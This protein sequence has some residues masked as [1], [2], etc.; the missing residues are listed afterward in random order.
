MGTVFKKTVTKAMPEGAELFSHKGERWARW[1]NAKGKLRKARVTT[2]E[3]GQDRI[4]FESGKYF[5]KYRDGSDVV[6][7][8]ATGCRD[9]DAARSFL[10]DLERRAELVKSGVITSGE[11]TVGIHGRRAISEHVKE[12]LEHQTAKGTTEGHRE[13]TRRFLERITHDCSFGLLTNLDCEKLERWMTHRQKENMSA[14]TRNAYR[15]AAVACGSWLVGSGRMLHNPFAKAP[16]ADQKS[17][18]RR[19]RRA[20]TEGELIKV[21]DV[22][23][24][25]PMQEARTVRRG[26]RKGEAYANLRD[27]TKASLERLGWERALIYKT[28]ILTGLRK[29]ELDSLTVGQTFLDE[30]LPY[31]ELNAADEKNRQGSSIMLRDD[32]AADLRGWLAAELVRLQ[33]EAIRNGD[34]IP[35]RLPADMP[36]FNVPSGLLRILDRDLKAAGIAKRDERGRTLDVHALRTTFGTLLSKGGVA[37]RTAQAAM[38]HSDI[39]LTMQ[40]YT[41]PKLLDVR[42]A[43]DSLPTLPLNDG[44]GNAAE[45]ARA[46]GTDDLGRFP[47]SPKFAPKLARWLANDFVITAAVRAASGESSGQLPGNFQAVSEH[48]AGNVSHNVGK[49]PRHGWRKGLQV[50]LQ[51]PLESTPQITKQTGWRPRSSPRGVRLGVRAASVESS[52]EFPGNFRAA[53]GQFHMKRVSARNFPEIFHILSTAT[54]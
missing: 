12:Y 53:S 4:V 33:A 23:R 54:I 6:R 30:S 49:C 36:L 50:T 38:R 48:L 31:V 1:K 35:A 20:M 42:G 32:L 34:P 9:E 5:A 24:R 8:V 41:D 18:P 40:T 44:Q 51:F 7:T 26:K 47:F 13:N 39:R 3:G 29:G 17:D 21:L 46:T 15:D 27:E 16:R 11:E 45:A 10:G 2:G 19:Q 37:P 14:R 28:L 22:A 25:R 43:L 52:R